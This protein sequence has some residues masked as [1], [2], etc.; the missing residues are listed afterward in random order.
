MD[1]QIVS[2]SMSGANQ[3]AVPSLLRKTFD[4][5]PGTRFIWHVWPKEKKFRIKCQRSR[6]HKGCICGDVIRGVRIPS[7]CKLFGKLC[8]PEHPIGACMVSS[9]GTCA[10]YYKYS[11]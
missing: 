8:K 7:E 2:T 4:I 10:A 11:V 5:K 6:E 9:E 3:L 1:L